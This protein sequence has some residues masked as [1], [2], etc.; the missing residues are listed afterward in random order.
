M[1][2]KLRQAAETILRE[3][4]STETELA[5]HELAEHY[6]ADHPADGDELVDE[7]FINSLG[8]VWDA[9]EQCFARWVK[10]EIGESRLELY[11]DGWLV[12][13]RRPCHGGGF[14]APAKNRNAVS[15]LLAALGVV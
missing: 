10:D 3:F 4:Q 6:L 15:S 9:G 13:G 1:S 12:I 7:G 8:F 5:A 11:R 14:I 2:E